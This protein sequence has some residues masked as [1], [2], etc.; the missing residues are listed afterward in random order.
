MIIGF[1]KCLITDFNKGDNNKKA[2]MLIEIKRKILRKI[3]KPFGNSCLL[4]LKYKI[5][6]N[7]IPR[8]KQKIM[9]HEG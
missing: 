1:S 5:P 2:I 4:F 6:E 3:I 9:N 8:S 7:I